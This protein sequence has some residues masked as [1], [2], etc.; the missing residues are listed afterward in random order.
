MHHRVRESTVGAVE[1]E[2]SSQEVNYGVGWGRE[3]LH[4]KQLESFKEQEAAKSISQNSR[5]FQTQDDE[6]IWQFSATRDPL[7]QRTQGPLK[8][9]CLGSLM[10]LKY[11]LW[12]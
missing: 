8:V 11:G 3:M 12:V 2:F 4:K 7:L 10:K 5:V 9:S 1:P 6:E